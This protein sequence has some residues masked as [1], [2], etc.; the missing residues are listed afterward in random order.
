MAGCDVGVE[1]DRELAV[2]A[3]VIRVGPNPRFSWAMLS[4]RTGCPV[5]DVTV[6][7]PTMLDVAPLVSRARESSP[8]TARPLR[9][10]VEISSSPATISRSVLPTVAMRT[11]RSAARDRSTATCTSGLALL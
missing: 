5:G 7:L 11:P 1:V 10:S 4:I 6:S 2:R 9:D 8:D 3:R